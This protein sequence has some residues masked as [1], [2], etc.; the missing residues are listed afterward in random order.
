MILDDY[1]DEIEEIEKINNSSTNIFKILKQQDYENKHSTFL[2]WLFDKNA[3][4]GLGSDFAE[5]VFK[6]AFGEDCEIDCS[7]IESVR[8]EVRID[9]DKQKQAGKDKRRIDLLVVGKGFTCTIENKY[10]SIEHGGQCADYREYIEGRKN[11][12]DN[13]EGG[14][15]PISEGWKNYFV[16]LD[17]E[18]PKDFKKNRKT[19]YADFDILEYKDI[20]KILKE[21]VK[22]KKGNDTISYINQYIEI[23]KERYE[24]LGEE[25]TNL[26]SQIPGSD[27]S[28]ILD[29]RKKEYGNLTE[30]ER[31]FVNIVNQYYEKEKNKKDKFIEEIVKG[32]IKD[33]DLIKPDYGVGRKRK[34]SDIIP[35]AYAIKIPDVFFQIEGSKKDKKPFIQSVDYPATDGLFIGISA[36]FQPKG[37]LYFI[38]FI[39]S[40]PSFWSDLDTLLK[41]KGWECMCEYRIGKNNIFSGETANVIR[42]IKCDAKSF[43]ELACEDYISWTQLGLAK[44]QKVKECIGKLN[45]KRIVSDI[46]RDN[47]YKTIDNLISNGLKAIASEWVFHL[48]YKLG[49]EILEADIDRCKKLY[50]EKTLEGMAI[51]GLKQKAEGLFKSEE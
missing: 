24:P 49:E 5:R 16:F 18:E 22:D 7:T 44:V 39:Q 42:S 3:S 41:S 23:L 31:V 47:L 10:G 29:I 38:E 43:K 46:E 4:H 20:K 8:T 40:N 25:I 32:I 26:C 30:S 13:P 45:E 37:S 21:L 33:P 11:E 48:K 15:Y 17:I 14:T 27:I 51:F 9:G 36:G 35:Y 1:K 50:R 34:N 12:D 28:N 6:R 2:S 19:R